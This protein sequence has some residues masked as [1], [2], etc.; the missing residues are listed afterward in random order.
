MKDNENQLTE[1]LEK[2][3]LAIYEITKINKAARVKD[4]SK[5]RKSVV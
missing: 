2:Y 3:L 4:V 1:S 5:D